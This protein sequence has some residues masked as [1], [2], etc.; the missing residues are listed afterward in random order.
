[1]IPGLKGKKKKVKELR[2]ETGM[3]PRFIKKKKKKKKSK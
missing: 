2:A 3:K 1:M